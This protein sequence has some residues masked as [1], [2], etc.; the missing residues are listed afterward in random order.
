MAVKQVLIIDNDGPARLPMIQALRGL[1]LGV[2]TADDAVAAVSMALRQHPQ[3]IVLDLHIPGGDGYQLMQRFQTLPATATTPVIVCTAADAT[4]HKPRALAAGAVEFLSKPVDGKD[5]AAAVKFVFGPGLTTPD[6]QLTAA[7][8]QS[9]SGPLK[10]LIVDDDDDVRRALML[11][12]KAQ[13]YEVVAAEDAIAAVRMAVERTPD[14]VVLD[15][16]L[17]G[18]EGFVVMERLQALPNV[19]ATPVVVISGRDP[20]TVR[21]RALAM[22]AAAFLEKPTDNRQLLAAVRAAMGEPPA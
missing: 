12:F 7:H 6:A 11:L 20:R 8:A 16:G 4:V 21:D 14:A 1:G 2:L 18:G 15:V 22:G 3:L 19:A 10:V 9:P 17:P 13:G 5:L